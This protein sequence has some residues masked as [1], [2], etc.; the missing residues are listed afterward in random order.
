[1]KTGKLRM[2]STQIASNIRQMSWLQLLVGVLQRVYQMLSEIDQ[3]RYGGQFAPY[4]KGSSGRYI[5]RIK[6]QD[7]GSHLER[8]G[9]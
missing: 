7:S 8:I 9:N 5:C 6:G 2:D 4:L 1:M 3:E